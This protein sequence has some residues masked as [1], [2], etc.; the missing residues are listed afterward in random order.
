MIDTTALEK[1]LYDEAFAVAFREHHN[2][3]VVLVRRRGTV[4]FDRIR[5][6]FFDD[7]KAAS[8]GV[9]ISVVPGRT[10]LKSL[11]V[12][13]CLIEVATNKELGITPLVGPDGQ[14]LFFKQIRDVASRQCDVLARDALDGLLQQTERARIAS[15]RYLDLISLLGEHGISKR[16]SAMGQREIDRIRQQQ[17]VCIPNGSHFY[18]LALQAIVVGCGEIEGDDQ[19]LVGKNADSQTE[20]ELMM[21]LQIMASRLAGER[22]WD[23]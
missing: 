2:A 21:R 22:G 23:L 4:A 13:R 19:W 3:G 12:H 18:V 20:R 8:A 10:A 5:L 11:C 16:V 17:F 6:A 7:G 15:T 1:D 14:R 9:E